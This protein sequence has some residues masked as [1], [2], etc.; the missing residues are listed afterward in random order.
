MVEVQD[1]ETISY[2]EFP[3]C[4]CLL[5]ENFEIIPDDHIIEQ[6][7]DRIKIKGW[8]VFFKCEDDFMMARLK[9]G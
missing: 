1:D 3:Y 7:C 6:F 8:F 2:E 5:K 9:Y 4:F